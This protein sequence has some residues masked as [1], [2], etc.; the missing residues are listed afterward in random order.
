MKGARNGEIEGL[1]KRFKETRDPELRDR[2][3]EHY[4]DLVKYIAERLKAKLPHKVD[5]QE[6]ISAGMIGLIRAVDKFDPDRGILFETYCTARIRGAI[7]DDIRDSD[8]VPRLVRNR[9]NRLAKARME[10]AFELGREPSEDELRKHLGLSVEDY[11]EMLKEIDVRAQLPMESA[12]DDDDELQHADLIEDRSQGHPLDKLVL[13][14]LKEVVSKRL[15]E[16]ERRI[17]IDYYFR[18][19]TMKEI[20]EEM[21]V[22][23][24]RVCQIHMEILRRLRRYLWKDGASAA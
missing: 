17:V 5:L 1:W 3:I 22:T 9:A 16:K 24:S 10:L 2:L 20:G 14:E 13:K 15:P 19:R 18:G 8:W 23:E 7:L 11:E 6:M 4:M 21:G 12:D